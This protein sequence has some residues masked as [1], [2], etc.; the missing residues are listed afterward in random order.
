MVQGL[1]GGQHVV[2][3]DKCK[4]FAREHAHGR[5]VAVSA[6][7]LLDGGLVGAQRDVAKPEAG[8]WSCG[9]DWQ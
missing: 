4:C 8:L 1:G 9:Q 7:Q 5:H 2:I 6:K 3:V